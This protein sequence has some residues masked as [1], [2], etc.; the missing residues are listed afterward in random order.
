MVAQHRTKLHRIRLRVSSCSRILIRSFCGKREEG[1]L[2]GHGGWRIFLETWTQWQ[3]AFLPIKSTSKNTAGIYRTATYTRA[4]STS[5]PGIAKRWSRSSSHRQWL[6][7]GSLVPVALTGPICV[8]VWNYV[9]P[10]Q[11]LSHV[12][13]ARRP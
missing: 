10:T 6:T 11:S 4:P 9:A 12:R 7:E 13:R 1:W 2:R 3:S 5:F 8:G